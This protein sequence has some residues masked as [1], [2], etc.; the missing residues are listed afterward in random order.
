MKN[1]LVRSQI[2]GLLRFC[3]LLKEIQ[4][5]IKSR[6]DKSKR[7][8][9][10]TI[11]KTVNR[12]SVLLAPLF[13]FG[14]G[15]FSPLFSGQLDFGKRYDNPFM[16]D[17]CFFVFIG[18]RLW[19]WSF[20]L[21][22][23]ARGTKSLHGFEA[24]VPCLPTAVPDSSCTQ[25]CLALL[26]RGLGSEMVDLALTLAPLLSH[27]WEGRLGGVW[28]LGSKDICADASR[29]AMLS[30]GLDDS[31]A[32]IAAGPGATMAPPCEKIFIATVLCRGICFFFSRRITQQPSRASR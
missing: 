22:L 2:I 23:L 6:V 15:S 14:F 11:R 26:P 19:R 3:V 4:V 10:N 24:P 17:R 8:S 32:S 9:L 7:C 20:N 28:G 29:L 21:F 5:L 1:L 27:R 18:K 16:F 25:Q 30:K 13:R 31:G 12:C